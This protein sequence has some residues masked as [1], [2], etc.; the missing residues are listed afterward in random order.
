MGGWWIKIKIKI[1][2]K[3]KRGVQSGFMTIGSLEE[4]VRHLRLRS[5][6]GERQTALVYLPGLHGD[7]TLIG[8]FRKALR[9]RVRFVEFTYPRT[10]SWSLDDYA[11]EIEQAL[12]NQGVTGGW[13]LGESFGSQVV[14][15]IVQ[16]KVF[17]TEGVVLAG[18]FVRHPMP[19]GVRLAER[20]AAGIPLGFVAQFLFF[21]AR[22]AR[23]RFRHSPD[24]V[25]DIR[26]FVERRTDLD[27]RAVIH[28]LCLI[29][30]SDFRPLAANPGVP[31][32]SINGLI[33][34]IVPWP[35]TRH[36]L[37]KNCQT[38]RDC[39]LIPVADHNVLGTAP[40]KSAEII[41]NWTKGAAPG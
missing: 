13:L 12:A 15:A 32:F 11:R 27:R 2:I 20:A 5:H 10:L 3:N 25:A 36:W 4:G 34:P 40:Q 24:Q 30:A 26:E 39:R 9:D 23:F 6:P 17:K 1:K 38:L 19:W 21:Y 33:D 35:W 29:A 18:G 16:R 31:V 22:A 28:R 7:W 8:G 37:R 41:V 14:W